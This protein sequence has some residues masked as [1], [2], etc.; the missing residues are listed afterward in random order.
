MDCWVSN[1][2]QILLV[3]VDGGLLPSLSPNIWK[4]PRAGWPFTKRVKTS[5]M[6]HFAPF[7]NRSETAARAGSVLKF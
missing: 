4:T 1:L 2:L 6:E 5:T 3:I 7:E